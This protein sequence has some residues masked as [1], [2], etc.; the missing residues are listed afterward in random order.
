M[1]RKEFLHILR[2]PS[3]LFFSLFIP[4]VELFL[5]GYAININIRHIPTVIF[6]QAGTQESREL[7]DRFSNS[8]DFDIVGE[9]FTDRALTEA[10]VSGRAHVGLK[11]PEDYSRQIMAGQTAQL[12]VLVDGSEASVA[13]EALNVSNAIALRESLLT[14][15]AGRS[16]PVESRPEVLFNP[17]TRSANFFVPGLLVVLCQVMAIMLTSNS[18]VREKEQGTLE[19]LFLTPVRTMELIFGKLVPYFCLTMAEFCVIS[20]LMYTAFQVP[21]HGSYLTLLVIALPFILGMLGLGLWIST[22]ASTRDAALQLSMGT[23]IPTFLL[24]GYIFPIESM[25]R[26]FQWISL[27][28]P[29]TWMIDAA[30]GVIL[31]GAGW[32]ELRE[33]ALVLTAMVL[34]LLAASMFRFRKRL[35]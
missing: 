16:L 18:I 13:A 1:A 2:D 17:D 24:S 8:D 4:I 29:T 7:I 28:I 6:D 32:T 15:L 30:R 19:E 33:H 5:L 35:A 14:I 20:F 10:I 31:H 27:L 22:F 23:V 12:L 11:I 9:V 26:L 21:I 3:T 34:A 25:P